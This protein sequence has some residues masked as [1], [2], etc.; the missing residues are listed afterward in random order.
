MAEP[1]KRPTDFLENFADRDFKGTVGL[2]V[3]DVPAGADAKD[4]LFKEP[5]NDGEPQDDTFIFDESEKTVAKHG[6]PMWYTDVEAG[7]RTQR[8]YGKTRTE[9][10]K[11]LVQ[12]Q[13][14]ATA[15][16][17]ELQAKPNTP[18]PPPNTPPIDLVPD[19]KLPYDPIAMQQP[20]NLSNEEMIA[21]VELQSSNP[22]EAQ[23]RL[24]KA[25][26]GCSPEALGQAVIRLDRIFANNVANEAAFGFQAKHAETNDWE[27]TPGNSALV[28]AY[29]RDRQ[30]PVTANNLEIAFQDLRRQG[31]LTMPAPDVPE[32]AA[33]P[34]NSLVEEVDPPPPPVVVPSGSAP[35]PGTERTVRTA[36]EE[37][38]SLQEM[39]LADMRSMIV[40]R[41]RQAKNGRR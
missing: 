25:M 31:R 20:R 6:Q 34:P 23:R 37:A 11:A 3:A 13:K 17:I 28:N 38:A 18:A 36:R 5:E 19:T 27:P 16:I 8:F 4:L 41:L 12:A 9:V 15:K 7:G 21:I 24:F 22:E 10:A 40:D 14:H 29:L 39:P 33:A 26:V 1:N 2:D 30:W 35:S 32:P